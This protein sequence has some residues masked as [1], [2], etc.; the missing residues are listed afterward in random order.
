MAIRKE[1]Q[2]LRF[3]VI[4]AAAWLVIWA[5]CLPVI[6]AACLPGI[7]YAEGLESE[8][9]AV[10]DVQRIIDET[11]QGQAA[12]KRVR[13]EADEAK[14]ELQELKTDF[15]REREAASKQ[16]ALLSSEARESKLAE[17]RGKERDLARAVQ[18]HQEDVLRLEGSEIEKVVRKINE[19]IKKLAKERKLDFVLERERR[20]VLYVRNEID[21]TDEVIA[22]M[23]ND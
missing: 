15:E 5:A 3:R 20:L 22:V 19:V 12:R 4:F 8:G 2:V 17:M 7:S 16:L 11:E 9:I 6:R 18:D 1:H 14:E 21:L 13:K 23:N 10:V